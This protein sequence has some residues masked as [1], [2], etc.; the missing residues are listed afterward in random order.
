MEEDKS[1]RLPDFYVVGAAKAG[2]TS[3]WYYLKQHPDLF[4]VSDAKYKELGYFASDHG[5]NDVR[6]YASFFESA[7]KNQMIGEVCNSYISDEKSATKINKAIPNAKI[8]IILREPISRAKSLYKW[9]FQE[10][11]ESIGSFEKALDA[12]ESRKEDPDFIN[13]NPHGNY[14]NY[15]YKETGLY[16]QQVKRY[17]DVFGEENC[18]ICLFDDL[19]NDSPRLMKGLFAF[20][21]VQTDVDINYVQQ[22]ISGSVRYPRLQNFLRTTVPRMRD[23]L[24]LPKGILSK[25]INY[26]LKKNKTNR[27]TEIELSEEELVRL[28]DFFK[29][30]INKTAE[31]IKRDL[32]NWN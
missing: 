14:R 31:L 8:I 10:G 28:R 13:N 23:R 15:L 9:M 32:S 30:D 5:I 1:F 24:R 25:P 7:E 19:K 4:L 26:V 11:Y 29:E 21:G 17:L 3:L 16:Y 6:E 18:Y 22:N 27:K 12:E 20:L 2:T